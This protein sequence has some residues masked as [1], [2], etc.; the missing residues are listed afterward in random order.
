MREL[1][2]QSLRYLGLLKGFGKVGK[3]QVKRL[4]IPLLN[5]KAVSN[6]KGSR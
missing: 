5:N 3:K 2:Q 6:V 4:K 1:K